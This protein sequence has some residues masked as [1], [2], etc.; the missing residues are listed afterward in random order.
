MYPSAVAIPRMMYM[1]P[2]NASQCHAF[3]TSFSAF[4]TSAGRSGLDPPGLAAQ[5]PAEEVSSAG[6]AASLGACP[7][8]GGFPGATDPTAA[9]MSQVLLPIGMAQPHL[10]QTAMDLYRARRA[11]PP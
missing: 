5:L 9:P 4:W 3:L 1:L 7:T 11:E 2:T 8:R 10:L 6:P